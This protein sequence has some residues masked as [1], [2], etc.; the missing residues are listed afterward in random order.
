MKKRNIL[1]VLSI[2]SLVSCGHKH[3][4][5]E[6]T[7][8][9]P[10]T[11]TV[12]GEETRVCD[13]GEKQ[14]RVIES[15]G[16]KEIIDAAV[17]VTCTADGKTEG[18]HCEECGEVFIAQDVIKSNG[19][20][21]EVWNEIKAATT[22]QEGEY[23]STCNNCDE[24]STLKQLKTPELSIVKNQLCWN[25]IDNATGYLLY[26]NDVLVEQ[27]G[28]VLTYKVPNI[29]GEHS[30]TLKALT[31]NTDYK[32]FSNVS[33]VLRINVAFGAN[34]QQDKGTNFERFSNKMQLIGWSDVDFGKFAGG[35]VEI[36][37]EY[38][39]VFAKLLPTENNIPAIITKS[40]DVNVLNAGTY[41]LEFDVKTN[42]STNGLLSFTLF[43]GVEGQ[44]PT[45]LSTVNNINI[46]ISTVKVNTW[47]KV[48]AQFVVEE[49]N[50]EDYANLDLS[51]VTDNASENNYVLIDN[52]N[53]VKDGQ[54]VENSKNNDFEKFILGNK[55]PTSG[56][57]ADDVCDVI[58]VEPNY[59]ENSLVS[60][61]NNTYL[62]VYSSNTANTDI[63]F[64]AN[65]KVAEAG[66]YKISMKVKL[67]AGASIVDNIG[68]RFYSEL[69]KEFVDLNTGDMVF[70]K[71]DT[72]SSEQ[73]VTLE[74][75]FVVAESKTVDFLN[76]YCWVFTHNDKL[77]NQDNYVLIDD[78]AISKIAYNIV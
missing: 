71:L 54:V 2:L 67:G 40:C 5:G 64:A 34:L 38:N 68:F 10:V 29:E 35:E 61:N 65:T 74:H 43:K 13:C 73:W 19:H 57:K 21:F 72:L 62:K 48:T 76:I 4:Y 26:D 1:L 17:K 66:T 45:A 49:N 32:E 37:E 53:I 78:L 69:N 39:N 9:K 47:T 58:H 60:E 20:A 28:D 24:V 31:D 55:L 30:Y 59:S 46:D 42:E 56:W 11:C 70:D 75:V 41:T 77:Q 16:H 63:T 23:T 22:E 12:D 7:I 18:K 27:L 33:D 52:F 44:L 36:I 25:N 8:T 3:T 6:W 50:M 15:K 14:T 51:F